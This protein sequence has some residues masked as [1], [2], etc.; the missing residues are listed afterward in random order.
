MLQLNLQQKDNEL[1]LLLNIINKSK[2]SQG[3]S[4]TAATTVAGLMAGTAAPAAV[5]PASPSAGA[6]HSPAP[7]ASQP[8]PVPPRRD[9]SQAPGPQQLALAS[10]QASLSASYNLD[11]LADPSLLKD[12]TAAYE[13]RVSRARRP[14]RPRCAHAPRLR[15]WL[16][17]TLL[18]PI[19]SEPADAGGKS[20]PALCHA[21]LSDAWVLRCVMVMFCVK[22]ADW[23]MMAFGAELAPWF[24][25]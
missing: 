16:S 22:E 14:R 12:R 13:V 17:R 20:G 5:K 15:V 23:G 9:P 2:D 4:P 11:A 1:Q 19:M 8:Q 3:L 7:S 10:E 18:H 6:E 25:Q 24:S 21:C